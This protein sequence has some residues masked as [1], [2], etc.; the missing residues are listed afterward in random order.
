[1][2]ASQMHAE[3]LMQ[4]Q[5]H[6]SFGVHQNILNILFFAYPYSAGLIF[7]GFR[8]K[9]IGGFSAFLVCAES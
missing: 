2:Q 8:S 4:L 1:M 6:N 9:E 3:S 7:E 5:I